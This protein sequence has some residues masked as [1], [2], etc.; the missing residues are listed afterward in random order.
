MK[1]IL[2][3]FI[4]ALTMATTFAQSL[5]MRQKQLAA[6][7]ALMAQG[8]LQRLEPTIKMALDNGVTINE[9]KETFSQLY[10]YAGFPRALNALG[11]LNKVIEHKAPQWQEGR[12]WTRPATWD[13]AQKA[14]HQGVEMQTKLAGRP[15]DY[16]F[17]PQADHYLKAHLFGDI[18]ASDQ[19]SP[20]DREIVTLGALSGL[21]GVA[22][23]WAAHR[24]GAVNLGNSSEQVAELCAWLDKEG[25]TLNTAW[26]KGQ[27]NTAYAQYFVGESY[28]NAV[29][30]ANLSAAEKTALPLHNVTFEPACRNNWH[31]HHGA[32]QILI[33][34]SGKGWY[35]EWGKAPIA[36]T[37][38]MV[39]DIPEGVK[40]W[41]GAQKDSWFQHLATM[42]PTGGEQSNEWLE[43][44]SD[45][46]YDA[47]P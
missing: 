10:A 1:R 32:R 40:H 18:F 22:P 39:I 46:Q 5:T 8:N 20:A 3:T 36:L 47:L 41:H 33:C 6:C 31:I 29:Q 35:Q 2:V 12:P 9:L 27:S 19:L 24:Q 38:G 37:A 28:L 44:V 30:P 42:V 43:E 23:Q 4:L 17:S 45:A 34:V 13:D 11:V 15:F 14:Y 21:E 16:A 7:A 25:Y 26:D